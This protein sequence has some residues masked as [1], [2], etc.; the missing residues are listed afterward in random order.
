MGVGWGGYNDDENEEKKNEKKWMEY[1]EYRSQLCCN[2]F[3]TVDSKT[4]MQPRMWEEQTI[5]N[6]SSRPGTLKFPNYISLSY[7]YHHPSS[8]SLQA[9]ATDTISLFATRRRNLDIAKHWFLSGV[10]ASYLVSM[11]LRFQSISIFLRVPELWFI[12]TSIPALFINATFHHFLSVSLGSSPSGFR[13]HY[14]IHVQ[15]ESSKSYIT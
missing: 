2:L 12:Q 5:A 3:R 7:I 6:D 15:S 8:I 10:W 4:P 9:T 14:S 13:L 1:I 11:F